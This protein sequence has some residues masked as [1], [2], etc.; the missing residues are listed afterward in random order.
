MSRLLSIASIVLITLA[1][2]GACRKERE[3][4]PAPA[5]AGHEMVHEGH[6]GMDHEGTDH[7]EGMA[8]HDHEHME[9]EKGEAL[10]GSSVYQLD[11]AWTNQRGEEMQLDKLAG[12]IV[13]LAMVYTH[14]DFA[15]PRIIGDM[16]RIRAQVGEREEIAYALV[17][18]DPERD[19]VERLRRFGKETGLS[20]Q[21]WLLL[22]GPEEQVRELAAVFG[23]SYRRVSGTDF[24]HSNVISV[25]SRQGEIVHQQVGL[26]AE[27][28]EAVRAIRELK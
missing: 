17:S 4:E 11:H 3:K 5:Q 21:G 22:R 1:P 25:L 13:V 23:V 7:D 26:G 27:P 10:S 6:E 8:R 9:M 2:L 18:I 16:R 14:C 12:K 24:A 15:C 20:E 28:D 19:T